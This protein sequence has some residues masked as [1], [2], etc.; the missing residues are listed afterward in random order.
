MAASRTV[1]LYRTSKYQT[2]QYNSVLEYLLD[3]RSEAWINLFG[4]IINGKLFAV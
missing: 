1:L 2:E 3:I 4:E